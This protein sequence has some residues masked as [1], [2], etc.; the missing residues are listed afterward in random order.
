M[1]SGAAHCD[2]ELHVEV[3]EDD[4]EDEDRKAE[5]KEKADDEE[6]EAESIHKI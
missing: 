3:C 5:K 4:G 1:R 2:L 6:K